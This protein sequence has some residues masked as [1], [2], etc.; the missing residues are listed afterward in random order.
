MP[1]AQVEPMG[2]DWRTRCYACYRPIDRCFCDKIPTIHNRTNVLIFQHMRERFHAFNTARILRKAL[3][4][5]K[6]VVDHM[7]GLVKAFSQMLFTEDTGLLYPGEDAEMLEELSPVEMP[8]QLVVLDGTWHHTKTLFRDIPQLRSL[9]KVRLTPAQPS[10]YGIRREPHVSFLSTLEATVAALRCLEP[11]TQGFDQLE[12]AFDSMVESQLAH[13]KSVDSVRRKHR[14]RAPLN[15]PKVLRNNLRNVVVLYGETAPGT[16]TAPQSGHEN[17]RGPVYW[18]AERLDT[19][20]RFE[21]AILPSRVLPE[22][23]L[24]HLELSHRAF[25]EAVSMD[26]FRRE[27]VS[28]LQ[29]TDTLAYYYSNCTRLLDA[30]GGT[31]HLKVYLKSIQ[32]HRGKKNGTLEELLA[33]LH[34]VSGDAHCQGRAGERLASSV[35]LTRYLNGCALT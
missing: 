25:S 6:I 2:E 1:N 28:F 16:G 27:W 26:A 4:N 34:V 33:A 35:A 20:E 31:S 23:F 29:P 11:E 15:I 13:P 7:E 19:G 14:P 24:G 22:S 3:L 10:R 5:S 30:I 18:V 21:R 8:K 32:L 12:A 17:G 9:R